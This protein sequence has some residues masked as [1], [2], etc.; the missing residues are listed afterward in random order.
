MGC[1]LMVNYLGDMRLC[2]PERDAG[3][4]PKDITDFEIWD[5][6]RWVHAKESA[7]TFYIVEEPNSVL[8]LRRS[9]KLLEKI[10]GKYAAESYN[11]LHNP[12]Y[13]NGDATERLAEIGLLLSDLQ[14][15]LRNA[16]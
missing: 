12:P 9:F 15:F 2:N 1:V 16:K 8:L 13:K 7:N 11:E 10:Y 6:S 14:K 3:K 4:D 5:G